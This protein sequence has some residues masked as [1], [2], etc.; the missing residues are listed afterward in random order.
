MQEQMSNELVVNPNEMSLV[1][2]FLLELDFPRRREE[3]I[4]QS[5][6]ARGLVV[7][8]TVFHDLQSS[9]AHGGTTNK[10]RWRGGRMGPVA[11]LVVVFVVTLG[12]L[13]YLYHSPF[14]PSSL[15]PPV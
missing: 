13:P 9:S 7:D 12:Q 11:S 6:E 8:E 2:V 15:L 5:A 3:A 14:S 1:K 4:I 10:D